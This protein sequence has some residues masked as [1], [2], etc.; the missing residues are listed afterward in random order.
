MINKNM[1]LLN[2]TTLIQDKLEYK[3]YDSNKILFLKNVSSHSD[4][5][6]IFK[7]PME[8]SEKCR[9]IIKYIGNKEIIID[10]LTHQITH[11]ILLKEKENSQYLID[12]ELFDI[13]F[14]KIL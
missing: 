1:I 12:K 13:L 5:I 4:G 3:I 2:V 8:G 9:F 7:D 6:Y 10:N 14:I 11:Y